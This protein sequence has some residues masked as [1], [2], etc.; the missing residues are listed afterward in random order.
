MLSSR[1]GRFLRARDVCIPNG[2][3][4]SDL[5]F[6]SCFS[7]ALSEK[8][9]PSRSDLNHRAAVHS[10]LRDKSAIVRI[11][12]N[13]KLRTRR[14]PGIHHF[15]IVRRHPFKKIENDDLSACYSNLILRRELLQYFNLKKP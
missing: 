10:L 3:A 8:F 12:P 15:F 5:L 9:H 4:G 11:L 7:H 14:P 1:A 2:V 6:A 13:R